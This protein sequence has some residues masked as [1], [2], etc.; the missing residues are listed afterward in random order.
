MQK[1]QFLFTTLL[2]GLLL[3]SINFVDREPT[4]AQSRIC[5]ADENYEP[6]SST[7]R[8]VK[9]LDFGIELDIPSNYR[10]MRRQ[11]GSVEILHPDDFEF[12]QCISRGGRGAGGGY[13][14]QDIQLVDRDNSMS[15]RE[16]AIWTV[17]YGTDAKGNRIPIADK[18]LDYR[19]RA[20]SGY[21]VTSQTGYSVVFMGVVQ[22]REK[23]LRISAGCDCPVELEDMTGL[24]SRVRLMK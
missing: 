9:I 6:A 13:Y 23:V 14:S 24:L 19:Q 21:I 12:F 2:S 4:Q 10:T 5:S 7:Y 22:G 11:D 8:S 18:V 16:Q 20:L 3:M 1:R 17:G 15:L